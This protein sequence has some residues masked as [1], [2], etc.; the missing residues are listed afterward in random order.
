[1]SKNKRKKSMNWYDLHPR[2]SI[3]KYHFG[4]ASVLLGVALAL[5]GG[6]E[7]SATTTDT[8]ASTTLKFSG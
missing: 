4:A 2:F 6:G 5:T 1:M 8:S 3:R 7:V